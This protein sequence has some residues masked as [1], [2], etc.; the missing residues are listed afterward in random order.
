VAKDLLQARKAAGWADPR[1]VYTAVVQPSPE[2]SVEF[3][4]IDFMDVSANDFITHPNNPQRVLLEDYDG[5][6]DSD[7]ADIT[8]LRNFMAHPDPDH[9]FSNGIAREFVL[10]ATREDSVVIGE[11]GNSSLLPLGGYAEFV[12]A[13]VGRSHLIIE[14]GGNDG[15][16]HAFDRETG[17][18]EWS[19]LANALLPKIKKFWDAGID[20]RYFMDGSCKAH[21]VN[22]SIPSEAETVAWRTV[23]VCPFG[24]GGR[25]LL[26]LDI[27]DPANPKYMWEVSNYLDRDA[28]SNFPVEADDDFET[29]GYSNSFP[30]IFRV[31]VGADPQ[32]KWL[33]AFGTGRGDPLTGR[34]NSILFIDLA[35]GKV[36]EDAG[37]KAI[38]KFPQLDGGDPGY[39]ADIA[40]NF[41][42]GGRAV[43]TDSNLFADKFI[44]AESRGRVW[45]IDV[46][47]S[48]ISDWIAVDENNVVTSNPFAD[49]GDYNM[50]G[51]V[52]N[53]VEALN[54]RRGDAVFFPQQVVVRPEETIYA[55]GTGDL[56]GLL[57][58]SEE[59]E[60]G[61]VGEQDTVSGA[62]IV[63]SENLAGEVTL[64]SRIQMRPTEKV[65]GIII[66]NNK[67]IFSTFREEEVA[68]SPG[69]AGLYQFDLNENFDLNNI[70]TLL[71]GESSFALISE[72]TSGVSTP[73]VISTNGFLYHSMS[74]DGETIFEVNI[75]NV[76]VNGVSGYIVF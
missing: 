70:D 48:R 63:F 19:F 25:G 15:F 67:V 33:T 34:G 44:I 32:A 42:S 64:L 20:Q 69:I 36:L 37:D 54:E 75:G 62:V 2:S 12:I 29:L 21:D 55:F 46:S 74:N 56:F 6:G 66:A 39:N 59:E 11:P 9:P 4:Q 58:H 50:D 73:L 49:L 43:D 35:T 7:L 17:R 71:Q 60:P 76:T 30:D 41:F 1:T 47:E 52:E 13:N 27:T 68:C 28:D 22:I 5:D 16:L 18:L 3:T 23:I 53:G 31:F 24:Q 51:T 26:A 57:G 45:K 10:G 8:Y 14:A 72:N 65:T 61:N 38:F 40:V